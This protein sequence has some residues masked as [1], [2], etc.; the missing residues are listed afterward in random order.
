MQIHIETIMDSQTYG[1]TSAWALNGKRF[2]TR[3]PM[4]GKSLPFNNDT[5]SDSEKVLCH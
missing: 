3:V 1:V 5:S 4:F 2:L